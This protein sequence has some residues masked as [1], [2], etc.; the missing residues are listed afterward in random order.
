MARH[1]KRVKTEPE[2]SKACGSSGLLGLIRLLLILAAIAYITSLLVSRTEGFRSLV[3]DRLEREIG[4]PVK[5]GGSHAKLNLDLVL[6]SI[7]T[8][9]DG[10]QNQPGVRASRVELEWSPWRSLRRGRIALDA[11][12]V[13]TGD[14]TFATTVSGQWEPAPIAPLSEKVASWIGLDLKRH[15]KPDAAVAPRASSGK[16]KEKSEKRRSAPPRLRIRNVDVSWWTE[17]D[18]PIG[19]LRGL[20]LTASSLAADDRVITHYVLKL[21]SAEGAK[22]F[23]ADDVTLELVDAGDQQVVLTLRSDDSPVKP[24]AA[25]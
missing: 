6:E 18:A 1:R 9:D 11:V 4:L 12:T 14:V 5:I 13:V 10:R 2:T 20:S 19:Q 21:G 24:A 25:E 7:R 8:E 3:A 16:P 15:V 17:G 23:R 22:G